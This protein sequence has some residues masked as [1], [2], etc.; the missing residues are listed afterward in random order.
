MLN[1]IRIIEIEG[2]GPGPFSAMHLADMGADVIV[3]HRKGGNPTPGMPDQ[4][5]IDRGKRSISL[6]LKD[7]NDVA[8]LKALLR[9]ADGLIEGF[10]PGVMEKLGLGPK[11]CH[12]VKPALVYGR[13]TGWGQSGSMSRTAG[14]DMNYIGVSGALWYASLP[15]Q[16]PVAPPTLVGDIGGGALYLT[17]GMLAGILNARATGKGTVVDAAIVDG[18]AHMMN[19]LMTLR[20]SGPKSSERGIGLL[21]GPHW[22]RTYVCA[23]GGFMSVQSLEPKFYSVFLRRLGVQD[24]P[25]FARQF[26]ADS[27]GQ[28]TRRLV[29][30]FATETRDYWAARF[31]GTDACAGPVLSPDEAAEHQVSKERGIWHDDDQLQAAAAPRFD[32]RAIPPGTP[33]AR[34]QHTEEILAELGKSIERWR[35]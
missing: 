20:Q 1:S 33:P 28:A 3:V 21:D 24:D 22:S 16:P 15:G 18:S 11:D 4:P 27:W 19:L 7:P 26:E 35:V 9:T 34:G 10:R 25:D 13:M 31:D 8:T 2:V 29:E 12:A 23:D 30:I 6:D 17:V 32:G 14:H 5:I